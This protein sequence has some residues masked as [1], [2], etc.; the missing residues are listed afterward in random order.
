VTKK[1]EE[2]EQEQ[3]EAAKRD[4]ALQKLIDQQLEADENQTE[5]SNY[6]I[7]DRSKNPMN[8]VKN[9]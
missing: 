7:Q 5:I 1:E 8:A 3:K 6:S 4:E 9:K 2:I